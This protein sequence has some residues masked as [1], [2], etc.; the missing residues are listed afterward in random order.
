MSLNHNQSNI[1]N[2]SS[3]PLRELTLL[4]PFTFIIKASV[5]KILSSILL[6]SWGERQRQLNKFAFDSVLISGDCKALQMLFPEDLLSVFNSISTIGSSEYSGNKALAVQTL[7]VTPG[8]ERV[9]CKRV[10][11]ST[12]THQVIECVIREE[13][14]CQRNNL[15]TNAPN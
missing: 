3:N 7:G 12:N 11:E 4:F 13:V 10:D 2:Q 6:Q 5:H 8:I 15:I 9:L 1:L 14:K